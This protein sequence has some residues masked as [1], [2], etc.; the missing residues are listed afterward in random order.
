MQTPTNIMDKDQLIKGYVS[1]VVDDLDI[2]TCIALLQEYMEESYQHYSY[3]VL[4][5]E[6]EEFYPHLL[7]DKE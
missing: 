3:E 4:K 1:E 5:E 2:E 7:S 6:V